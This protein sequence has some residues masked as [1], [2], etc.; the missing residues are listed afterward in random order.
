MNSNSRYISLYPNVIPVKGYNRS[1]LMDL[2]L[3]N[4]LFIPNYLCNFLLENEKKKLT[5]KDFLDLG[6]TED[7]V[8]EISQLLDSLIK[9]EYLTHI[10][11]PLWE[12]FNIETP[13]KSTDSLITDCIIEISEKSEWNLKGLFPQLNRIG[14]KFI[15]I[16][17][18]DFISFESKIN[19]LRYSVQNHSIEFIHLIVPYSNKLEE[20]INVELLGF[21]RLGQLTVYNTEKRIEIKGNHFNLDFTS[22]TSID[23]SKCGC[24]DPSYFHFNVSNYY[25]NRIYNNCLSHKLSIDQFGNIKNCPS[26]KDSFG[27]FSVNNLEQT[28]QLESFKKE[29]HVTKESILVC[30]DCEFR[31]MCSDCRVFIKDNTNPLSKPSKCGYNPY[32]SKWVNE[33]Y[34]LSEEECGI[35]FQENRLIIDEEL[36]E[37]TNKK[38]WG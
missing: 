26:K 23:D 11:L 12:G 21:E 15:E 4:F 16:R 18:L 22:Q 6:E 31:F 28:V 2:Y 10:D 3:G 5:E 30:S 33:E 9:K 25:S 17:F 13:Y 14:V 19:D 7:E 38:I 1:L 34:Y 36:L 8:K 35:K 29:W 32:I 24:I 37:T 27:R 20:V